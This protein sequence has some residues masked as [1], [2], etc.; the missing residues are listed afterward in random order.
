MNAS[1]PKADA[2]PG[3]AIPRRP[4]SA[5]EHSQIVSGRPTQPPPNAERNSINGKRWKHKV[6]A[7]FPAM[8]SFPSPSS[9]EGEK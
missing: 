3:C 2:L 6:P 7:K 1:A 9:P 5:S 4:A 8:F